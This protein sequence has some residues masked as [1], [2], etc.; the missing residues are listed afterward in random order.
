[1][2]NL[3]IVANEKGVSKMKP[4]NFLKHQMC[5]GVAIFL[6]YSG[7]TFAQNQTQN[8]S[9]AIETTFDISS[10]DADPL[11]EVKNWISKE[12]KN[13]GAE[14]SATV[15]FMKDGYPNVKL[16]SFDKV[17][18]EGMIF[19]VP[20]ESKA[21]QEIAANPKISAM[22]QWKEKND[23]ERQIRFVG[24]ISPT[25]EEQSKTVTY[26]GKQIQFKTKGFLLKPNRVQFARLNF[27][28]SEQVGVTEFVNYKLINGK[29]VKEEIQVL[30]F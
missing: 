30:P 12:P 28:Y 27:G 4:D 17:T 15:G 20:V 21:F 3:Q 5:L 10:F 18:P 1:M 11:K 14:K 25:G 23:V 19:Y 26:K 2:N 24:T 6:A 16:V 29:W 9:Y 13:H 7:L 22:I 8:P